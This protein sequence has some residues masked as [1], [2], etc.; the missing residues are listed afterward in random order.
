MMRPTLLLA[1]ASLLLSAC[2]GQ[3]LRGTGDMGVVVER[4]TGALQIIETS[5]Q[6]RLA[7]VKGLGDLSHA[8]VV[9]SRDERFAYVFGRD[10]GL[11]KV[12]LL[13]QRID[14][15][16]IQGGNSIGG[17]ISQDGKLIAV[18]NYEPGGV[19]V[20]DA[21]TLELV[22]DIPA[23]P[24]ADGSRNSR[25]V[26]VID[27]PGRR[28]IYSLFD[29][30]ETWLLDFSQGNSPEI[31][32][33]ENIGKQPYDGLLTPDGRYYI[34]GLFGEDGMA[35][36][37]LW[38]PDRGVERII[39]G[40]GRGEEKLPVYKMPHLEGWTV[41]GNQTFVPAIGHHQVLVMDSQSWEQTDA[42]DVAGQPVFVMARPDARQ[43][44]VNFAHPDNGKL[45]IIDSETHKV[46]QTLEPGPAVL[47]MEF[48]A[49]GDQLWLS[50]RDGN[51]VQ[52]WDPYTLK[53]LKRLPADSPSGIFF[54]SRAH[55]TGL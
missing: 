31:T 25:V 37:D 35:K 3:P 55:E 1:A 54:T 50:V 18:G 48:T 49:R 26:G 24:M 46:I 16:V 40:Y 8:S 22:A 43:I 44:W 2:A 39:D 28:F 21:D 13:R 45:Q 15:R 4:A 41:A 42:I 47:H 6:T 27:A 23:T 7:R 32:R 19:K 5:G 14:K 36:I 38:H 33:F 51:E 17:A 10:G 29:T 52:V 34:A 12:D 20:F 9:F 53:L 11:T 30:H